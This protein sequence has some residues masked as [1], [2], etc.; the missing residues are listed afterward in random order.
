MMMR[1]SRKN[2]V[3]LRIYNMYY[4]HLKAS[5][6]IPISKLKGI[7]ER[8][9]SSIQISFINGRRIFDTFLMAHEHLILD[10]RGMYLILRSLMIGLVDISHEDIKRY[11]I[12]RVT[13]GSSH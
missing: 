6:R 2:K 11:G 8:M 4:Q 13:G 3:P 10:M 12:Y 9:V 5:A 7:L 1:L